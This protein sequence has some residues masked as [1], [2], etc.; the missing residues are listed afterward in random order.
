MKKILSLLLAA[1]MLLGV[2]SGCGA[3]PPAD[4]GTGPKESASAAEKPA[5]EKKDEVTIGFPNV[6]KT[7]DPINGFTN[8]V[9]I[10]F[11]AL[12]QTNVKMEVVADLAAEYEI[13]KDALTYSFALRDGAKFSDGSP[14]TAEDVVFTYE[15]AKSNATSLDLSKVEKVSAEGN[16]IQI[17]LKAPDSTF[18]LTAAKV[19]IVPKASYNEKF[20]LEPVSSGP[21]KLV[22]YDVDQQ[23]I[24]EA[25]EHYYGGAPGINRVVFVKMSDRDT[26]LLAV[27]SGQADITLT[28]A[29]IAANNKVE[30][31]KLLQEKTVDNFGIAAP[32]VPDEGRKNADGN[33]VGNNVTCDIAIRK[34]LAYGIDRQKVC[35]EAL[36]GYAVPAY[37]ENDGMPWHNPECKIDYDLKYAVRLLEEAGWADKDGDGIREKNGVK[38]SFPLLYFVG[39]DVRQA[40]AMSISNQAKE[41]LGVEILVEGAGEDLSKRMFSEPLVLAWGSSNPKTSYKLFHSS[42]AGKADWYNPENFTNATVDKYLDA[43]IQASSLEEAIPFWQKAQWD[44]ETGTSMR[45]DCPYIFMLNKTHL[46]WV[47]EGL[48]TGNQKIHA[49]GDAWPLVENLREWKW[50]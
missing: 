4:T 31:Y 40:A 49:H 7:F 50:S 13:S 11:S 36:S 35:D 32:V 45:G 44:G 42:N 48:D 30:G 25:N 28:S 5:P 27:K 14:I 23:F 26:R 38:A 37:S 2:L 15:T 1:L 47:R 22:Q 3:K 39:D 29:A 43:A 9:Q 20:A 8:G 16:K 24:L 19:G 17:K 12:V 41:N 6:P 46:Y 33:P 18:I 34:A 21:Y 10:M